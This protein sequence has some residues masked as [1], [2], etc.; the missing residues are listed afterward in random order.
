M[1]PLICRGRDAPGAA[2]GGSGQTRLP[3]A[4]PA[5][6]SRACPPGDRHRG[7]LTGISMA[8]VEMLA[9]NP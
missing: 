3:P 6:P 5:N 1:A 2:Q 4:R 8:G 7:L 9:P